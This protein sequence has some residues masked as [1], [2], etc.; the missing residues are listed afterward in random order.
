MEPKVTPCAGGIVLGDSGTLVLVKRLGGDGS[1]LFPKGH[2]EENET[3]EQAS[4][5][6]IE[7]ET[8][9]TSLEL[10]D[11]L[12]VYRRPAIQK[13]GI[14]NLL[15]LK[16][17]QMYLFTALPHALL[18]PS[19]EIEEARWISLPYVA[20]EVGNIHDRAW[21]TSVFERVREA[22]QRD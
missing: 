2:V 12:G 22:V 7:E 6:E 13:D 14:E 20:K 9:L 4:R 11:D 10:L 8:G 17:I 3:L 15:E 19:H 16:E 1:W 21:F 5:R 18:A